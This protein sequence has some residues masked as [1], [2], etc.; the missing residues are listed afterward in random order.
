MEKRMVRIAGA[1]LDMKPITASGGFDSKLDNFIPVRAAFEVSPAVVNAVNDCLSERVTC[2][3]ATADK[4]LE[5]ISNYVSLPISNIGCFSSP[6]TAIET[7]A[8]TYIEQ[9]VEVVVGSPARKE[10]AVT[11][12]SAG[13]TVIDVEHDNPFDPQIEAIINHISPRTRMVFMENPNGATGA[14]FSEAEIVFLLAYAE[15]TMVVIDERHFEH[16]GRTVAEL[17]KRFPNLMVIRSISEA[18][19]MGPLSVGY[20]LSDSENLGYL[21]RIAPIDSNSRLLYKAAEAVMGDM[22][23][24]K[25]N[26]AAMEK[27]RELFSQHLPELGYVFETPPTDFVL[28]NVGNMEFATRLFAD[29]GF[30]AENLSR[31]EHLENYIKV[32]I[33][34]PEAAEL[35]LM[36]L[37]L[38]A[39]HL[40]TGYNRN[41]LADMPRAIVGAR[42]VLAETR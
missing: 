30:R 35:L 27:A 37:S 10:F 38:A 21:N 19:G 2:A 26:Q 36:E 33:G 22:E 7:V 4:L 41:H 29:S 39:G 25:R 12:Q 28:L 8:R 11:A 9:G 3:A 16:G 23:Y 18:F 42:R 31:Y 14:V 40:A 13:A 32:E 20:V 5:S 1:L 6:E 24:L 34:N 17:V 15:S